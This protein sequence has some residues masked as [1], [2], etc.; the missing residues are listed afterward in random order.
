[1]IKLFEAFKKRN[2]VYK[3]PDYVIEYNENFVFCLTTS[4]STCDAIIGMA[5]LIR[6]KKEDNP[7]LREVPIR[8][9]D[10]TYQLEELD[11]GKALFPGTQSKYGRYENIRNFRSGVMRHFWGYEYSKALPIDLFMEFTEKYYPIIAD[12]IRDVKTLGDVIDKFKIIYTEI[13]SQL[14]P[15]DFYKDI[16]NYNL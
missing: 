4:N 10:I 12:A 5:D 3:G 7:E 6:M 14:E 8:K 11:L 9:D 15:I 13:M 16:K 2:I 1:M